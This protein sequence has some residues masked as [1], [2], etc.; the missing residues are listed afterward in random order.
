MKGE[1]TWYIPDCYWAE[2]GTEGPYVSHEAVCVLNTGCCDAAVNMTLY[3]EDR[4]P[5]GGFKSVC[6]AHRTHHIRMDRLKNDKGEAI[7]RGVPYAVVVECSEPVFVQYSR[8]DT[9][10][11]QMAFMTAIPMHD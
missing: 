4:D 10:Q 7:P 9:T 3:F 8:C 6:G 1:K 2:G 5:V 11:P